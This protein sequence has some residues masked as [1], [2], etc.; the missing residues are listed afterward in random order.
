MIDCFYE[1]F[2]E[3]VAYPTIVVTDNSALRAR[4]IELH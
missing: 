4:V 2:Y 3:R 1:T